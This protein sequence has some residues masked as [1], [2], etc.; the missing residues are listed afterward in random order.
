MSMILAKKK[1]QR[2]SEVKISINVIWNR[3]VNKIVTKDLSS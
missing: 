1:G 3:W 2:H